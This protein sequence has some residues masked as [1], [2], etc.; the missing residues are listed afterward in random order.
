MNE[1]IEEIIKIVLTS[2]DEYIREYDLKRLLENYTEREND[3][4]VNESIEEE[5]SEAWSN[6]YSH[7]KRDAINDMRENFEDMLDNL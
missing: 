3:K 2:K 1:L 5:K 6:G 4:R 7:G